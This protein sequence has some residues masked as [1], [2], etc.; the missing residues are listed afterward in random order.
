MKPITRKSI[1]KAIEA[2]PNIKPLSYY[3]Y[4]TA[5]IFICW[6]GHIQPIG[7]FKSANEAM[8]KV[9]EMINTG[10]PVEAFTIHTPDAILC[11]SNYIN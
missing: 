4:E 10:Q 8:L 1:K 11:A 3:E 9:K 2:N 6:Y 7:H 5:K